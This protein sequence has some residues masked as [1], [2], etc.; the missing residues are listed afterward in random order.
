MELVS[1]TH[2]GRQKDLQ[3][4][5]VARN[6]YLDLLGRDARFHGVQ[7]LIVADAGKAACMR[8]EAECVG[9]HKPG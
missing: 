4:L 7:Y 2:P 6:K 9:S 5:A 1:F 8:S 3:T